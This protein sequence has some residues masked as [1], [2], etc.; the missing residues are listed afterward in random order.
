MGSKD[1]RVELY[2]MPASALGTGDPQPATCPCH[3]E[4]PARGL[5]C[6]RKGHKGSERA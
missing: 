1:E 3:Q 6:Q 5:G 4:L 2:S